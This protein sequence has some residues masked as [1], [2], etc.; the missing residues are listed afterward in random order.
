MTAGL[1]SKL[2]LA[3]GARI[4]LRRNIDVESG[5]VNGVIGTVRNISNKQVTIQFDHIP[6]HV[7]STELVVGSLSPKICTL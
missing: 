7:I 2:T 6:N 4:M 1:E 5:L 3:V